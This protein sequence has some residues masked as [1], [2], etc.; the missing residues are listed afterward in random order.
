[1]QL[2]YN[3]VPKCG[4]TTL[5]SIMKQSS[6]I[7]NFTYIG[8]GAFTKPERNAYN[9][10]V[11]SPQIQVQGRSVTKVWGRRDE[12]KNTKRPPLVTKLMQSCTGEITNYLVVYAK[13]V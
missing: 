5:L 8:V 10:Y 7:Y 6:K 9:R 2:V 12:V 1:M 13:N 11:P 4:S 3:R